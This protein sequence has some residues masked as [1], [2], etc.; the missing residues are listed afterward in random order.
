MQKAVRII[1]KTDDVFGLLARFTHGDVS[2]IGFT[3]RA[4][5]GNAAT[6]NNATVGDRGIYFYDDFTHKIVTNFQFTLDTSANV[7]LTVSGNASAGYSVATAQHV[8]AFPPIT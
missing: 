7:S 1:N 4:Q 3:L 8:G 2:V 6:F 5:Q